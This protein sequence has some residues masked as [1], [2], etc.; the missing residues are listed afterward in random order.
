MRFF[1]TV[2]ALFKLACCQLESDLNFQRFS[3]DGTGKIQYG[4]ALP[5][6][7]RASNDFIAQMEC[8]QPAWC[9]IALGPTMLGSLLIP[10]WGY[11]G[12]VQSSIRWIYKET[13]ELRAALKMDGLSPEVDNYT[14]PISLETYKKNNF[15][16]VLTE[17]YPIF[18]DPKYSKYAPVDKLPYAASIKPIPAW[19]SVTETTLKFSF[20]CSKCITGDELTQAFANN[21]KSFGFAGAPVFPSDPADP[22]GKLQYHFGLSGTREINLVKATSPNFAKVAAM[23]I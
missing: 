11:K 20:L 18:K 9:G 12:K 1:L 13:D 5:A 15:T 22:H 21:G 10:I 14:S 3:A 4:I 6:G 2:L 7:D 19:T 23:A 8:S 17:L 16:S